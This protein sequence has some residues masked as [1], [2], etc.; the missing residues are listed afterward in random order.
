MPTSTLLKMATDKTLTVFT[1]TF[2]R[3]ETL[4]DCYA[5]LKRQTNGDFKWLVVDD[6][7]SDGTREEVRR[8]AEEGRVEIEYV[9]QS[10]QGMHIA[11]NTAYEN[12]DT[13][14]CMCMDSDDYLTDDAI[15][16]VLDKWAEVRGK[17][18]A[19][20][21][22]LNMFK[23]GNIIGNMFEV[24]STT[25]TTFYSEGGKGDKKLVYVT[26]IVKS[27]PPYPRFNGEKYVG[28]SYKY[29]MIDKDYK[30]ATMNHPVCVVEY[31]S[32]GSTMNMIREYRNNPK[33][34]SALR[35]VSIANS[36]NF[37]FKL[38]ESVHYVS[39]S[40]LSGN[41]RYVQESPSPLTAL[42]A[43]PLGV[44]LYLIVKHTDG[45]LLRYAGLIR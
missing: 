1:P 42:L 40:L 9:Y 24:E 35:R 10:N 5:S 20:I 6:G 44:A 32:D 28:L 14:L 37:L 38:K 23:N 15:E 2:N 7:S 8:W 13:E 45:K 26:D 29:M 33:G 27:Y 31:R 41:R 21:M 12:I 25:L 30:M 4:R 43:T 11:H 3:L 16:I 36:P 18:Y 34:F 22:A 17:K 19:G 39:S